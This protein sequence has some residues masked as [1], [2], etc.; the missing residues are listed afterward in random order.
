MVRDLLE[1]PLEVL[2]EGEE[3]VTV[4]REPKPVVESRPDLDYDSDYVNFL[5]E[6]QNMVDRSTPI[7]APPGIV[8]F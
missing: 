1:D 4:P 3:K 2:F 6:I 7:G 8:L 5:A